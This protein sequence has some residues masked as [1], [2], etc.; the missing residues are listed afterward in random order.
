MIESEKETIEKIISDWIKI[1]EI[2]KRYMEGKPLSK[3]T[4]AWISNADII[5]VNK[6]D[7]FQKLF[8]FIN[9]TNKFFKKKI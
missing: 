5:L 9:K 8:F 1:L 6:D 4:I 3:R 7:K 2:I